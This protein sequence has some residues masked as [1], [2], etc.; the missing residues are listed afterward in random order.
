MEKF[1]D[2][3]INYMIEDNKYIGYIVNFESC[4]CQANSYEELEKNLIKMA[5]LWLKYWEDIFNKE[6]LSIKKVKSST[7]QEWTSRK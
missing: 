2:I 1:E 3:R 4:L 5:K 6:D 7:Y